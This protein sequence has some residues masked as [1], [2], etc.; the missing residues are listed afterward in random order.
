MLV[1]VTGGTGFVGSHAVARL[2]T[3][4]HEVR[5]LVRDAARA[6]NLAALGVDPPSDLVIGDATD[7]HAVGRLL[8]GVDA[9]VH[10]AS[11]FSLDARDSGAIR[12]TNVASTEL[13]LGEAARRGLQHIVYVSSIAALVPAEH[14]PVTGASA[15]GAGVDD[16]TRSKAGA[17]AVARRLRPE[18]APIVSIM[19][20]GV[21]G[22]IDPYLSEINE[23][24][25]WALQGNLPLV[26]RRTKVPLVDVRDLA[27]VI[28]RAVE[29]G[30]PPASYT[31]TAFEDDLA[32]L[33]SRLAAA[34]GRRLPF[35]RVPNAM[36]LGAGRLADAVQPRIPWTLPLRGSAVRE[37]AS[38]PSVDSSEAS[39]VLGF[40]PRAP[41]ETITD[42]VRWL[43][44]AGHI[45]SK[46]AGRLASG[47]TA[48]AS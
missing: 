23:Q 14:E 46:Q 34:T 38:L 42:T 8:E 3:D 35:I 40:A 18:G 45:T 31:V 37:V 44:E 11:V 9:V 36:A 30:T 2:L 32:G 24:V 21:T 43:A 12:H 33:L 7:A 4:G 6:Q 5:L 48:S 19:P 20:G 29:E 47:V 39:R 13:V 22:P 10:A 41:E 15:L 27:V 28:A 17:E 25:R 16:Y 1:A 26:P